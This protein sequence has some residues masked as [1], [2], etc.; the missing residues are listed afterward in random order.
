[1]SSGSIAGGDSDISSIAGGED[2]A[3]R[4]LQ[5]RRKRRK[6]PPLRPYLL[7]SAPSGQ[8][9][10]EGGGARELGKSDSVVGAVALAKIIVT[11]ASTSHEEGQRG[12]LKAQAIR[13]LRSR[14]TLKGFLEYEV[15][16]LARLVSPVSIAEGQRTGPAAGILALVMGRQAELVGPGGLV[17]GGRRIVQQFLNDWRCNHT[18]KPLSVVT[19]SLGRRPLREAPTFLLR[20]SD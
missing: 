20:R 6:D 19:T 2:V 3:P 12:N 14:R 18:A 1:M 16:A 5:P 9:A 11:P 4:A 17:E 10:T 8:H 13:C 15:V 7:L